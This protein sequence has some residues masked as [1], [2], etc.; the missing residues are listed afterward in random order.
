MPDRIPDDPTPR[1][2]LLQLRNT[3]RDLEAI[4]R[5]LDS[6]TE[7]LT[8]SYVPRG[9]WAEARKA[10]DLR[11]GNIEQDIDAQAGF[12]RQVAAGFAVGFLLIIAGAV[13]TLA[14]VPGVG[15]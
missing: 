8:R 9:E 13:L 1:E 15:S 10:D 4:S 3:A 12:R 6:L 14:R 11:F 7:T 2:L 5:R